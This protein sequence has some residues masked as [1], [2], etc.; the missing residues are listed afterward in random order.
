MDV[1]NSAQSV[2]RRNLVSWEKKAED[3]VSE[4]NTCD[5]CWVLSSDAVCPHHLIES[6]I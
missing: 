1:G 5:D 4:T 3:A 2:A 6:N